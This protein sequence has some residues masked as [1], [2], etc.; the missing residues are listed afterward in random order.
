MWRTNPDNDTD[1]L[2]IILIVNQIPIL[3]FFSLL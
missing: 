3:L 2:S 1:I